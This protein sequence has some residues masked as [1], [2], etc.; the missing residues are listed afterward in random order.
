MYCFAAMMPEGSERGLLEVAASVN[1]GVFGCDEADVFSSKHGTVGGIN[2]TV[3]VVN[4]SMTAPFVPGA[5]YRANTEVF[6][7]IWHAVYKADKWRKYNWTLK[8]D[9]DTV[10]IPDAFRFSLAWHGEQAACKDQKGCWILNCGYGAI[11]GAAEVLS[12]K[13]M[14]VFGANLWSSTCGYRGA[15]DQWINNCVHQLGIGKSQDIESFCMRG[16]DVQTQTTR[17]L[18]AQWHVCKHNFTS[19]EGPQS[20]WH[21]AANATL[22]KSCYRKQGVRIDPF[23]VK[24]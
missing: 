11:F 14:A 15:E 21:P 22:M 5:P 2:I 24:S 8:L 17:F 13:A 20:V 19:C 6:R 16:C 18:R 10:F 1:Q 4:F 7:V 9:P 12:S 3:P 23:T